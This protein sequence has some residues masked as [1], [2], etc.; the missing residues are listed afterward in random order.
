MQG[1]PIFFVD[2]IHEWQKFRA[3]ISSVAK[4]RSDMSEIFL[5]NVAVVI[6]LARP[7]PSEANRIL[8][9]SIMYWTMIELINSLPES[10]F[11]P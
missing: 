4:E 1:V 6:F 8:T 2:L 10:V 9:S 11:T 3:L 7:R 5:F